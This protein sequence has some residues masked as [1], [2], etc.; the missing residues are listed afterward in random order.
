MS[1][2]RPTPVNYKSRHATDIVQ[3]AKKKNPSD[4]PPLGR[5]TINTFRSNES[6][7]LIIFL[8]LRPSIILCGSVGE[9][10]SRN[11]SSGQLNSSLHLADAPDFTTTANLRPGSLLGV[12]TT[13]TAEE[14]RITNIVKPNLIIITIKRATS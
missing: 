10:I 6:Q 8:T 2:F 5:D 7:F 3:R 13:I 12:A 11:C 9:N 14:T 1:I 4:T